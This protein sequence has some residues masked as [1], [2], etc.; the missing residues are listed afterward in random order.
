MTHRARVEKSPL[1][2]LCH[3]LALGCGLA[4][5]APA[6]PALAVQPNEILDDPDLEARARDL[7][8]ELRCVVCQNESIDSSN[9]DIAQQMRGV[10][11]ERLVAGDSDQEVLDF[12]QARYG[13]YVLMK[14]PVKPETYLLWYAPAG[15]LILGG[16]GAALYLAGR[17]RAPAAD[18]ASDP[19]QPLSEAER[20][21]LQALLDEDQA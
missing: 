9:A 5:A 2:R 7:S 16:I 14:P 18:P 4:L 13:D 20:R 21:R 6:G 12:L 15:I 10:V 1:R 19:A 8:K 11:R 17:R 3:A